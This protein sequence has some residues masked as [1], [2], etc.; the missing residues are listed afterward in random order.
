MKDPVRSCGSAGRDLARGRAACLSCVSD[1]LDRIALIKGLG[2]QRSVTFRGKPL[3][4]QSYKYL[5]MSHLAETV[6]SA[7]LISS[8]GPKDGSLVFY[9]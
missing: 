3:M 9:K 6:Q 4:C 7:P 5:E 8:R 2:E 1:E